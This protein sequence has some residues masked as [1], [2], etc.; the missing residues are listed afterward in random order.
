MGKMAAQPKPVMAT[1]TKAE[2][3]EPARMKNVPATINDDQRTH[4]EA[5]LA[6]ARE[7]ERSHGAAG[8]ETAVE[9]HGSQSR[10]TAAVSRRRLTCAAAQLPK[11][12]STATY[13]KKSAARVQVT[14]RPIFAAGEEEDFELEE[15]EWLSGN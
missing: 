7:N 1:L 5:K 12:V 15:A 10:D 4:H 3:C 2:I 6:H 8:H 11:L 14:R 13:R 9:K